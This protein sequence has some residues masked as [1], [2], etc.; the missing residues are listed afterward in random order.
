MPSTDHVHNVPSNT[1]GCWSTFIGCTVKGVL[2]DVHSAGSYTLVFGCGWG[3]T[4]SR[5][6][7]FW[8]EGQD[9]VQRHVSRVKTDLEGRTKELQEVVN[10][11][12]EKA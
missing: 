11:A 12:G 4:V 8:V 5:A 3:L 2:R 7:T 10:L 6:G 1:I 9:E